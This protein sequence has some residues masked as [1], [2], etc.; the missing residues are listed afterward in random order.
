M[1]TLLVTGGAGFIGS[2]FIRHTL[3]TRPHYRIV[4]LDALTYAGNV[5]SIESVLSNR[6]Q[7]KQGSID[8]VTFT[9]SSTV[10][11]FHA[12]LPLESQETLMKDVAIACIG[13][14]TADTARQLGF[15]VDILAESFTIP[16][17]C[18]AIEQYYQD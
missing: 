16:G 8:L 7:L 10:E 5:A 12:L 17:L 6:C 1:Q 13:P 4:N 3:D 11:N 2:N 9:S 14:I 15:T 18:K